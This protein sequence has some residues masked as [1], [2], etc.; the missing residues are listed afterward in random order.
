LTTDERRELRELRRRVRV[1][2]QE[3]EML[4]KVGMAAAWRRPPVR[5]ENRLAVWLTPVLVAAASA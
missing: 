2:E 1:L 3:R 4:K 5:D